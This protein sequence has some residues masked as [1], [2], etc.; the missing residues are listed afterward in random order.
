MGVC[1]SQMDDGHENDYN[2]NDAEDLAEGEVVQA[3]FLAAAR[4]RQYDNCHRILNSE[5]EHLE[6]D[7][8]DQKDDGK[9]A[10]HY[11]C[12]NGDIRLIRELAKHGASVDSATKVHQVGFKKVGGL[13]PLMVAARV[14]QFAAMKQLI[15]ESSP[16][17]IM[18]ITD[19][20]GNTPLHHAAT[21]YKNQDNFQ[22][23]L[24]ILHEQGLDIQA[25]DGEARTALHV[26]AEYGHVA[27]VQAL[28][29][30]GMD[31]NKTC[32]K[33][34]MAVDFAESAADGTPTTRVGDEI[35]NI[36]ERESD[37]L[38]CKELLQ[39]EE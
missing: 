13:T 10:M 1:D 23:I 38:E 25:V 35:P 31:R 26:A 7:R 27:A 14:G 20:A 39:A 12:Q 18:T 28:L 33:G 11:A 2:D 17:P 30:V 16:T 5:G 29:A 21:A 24:E 8:G 15:E 22:S 9:N 36:E 3:K 32:N 6:I 4:R 37:Y 19:A 34:K